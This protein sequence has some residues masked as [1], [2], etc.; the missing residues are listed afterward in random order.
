MAHWARVD[1]SRY[2]LY[3]TVRFQTFFFESFGMFFGVIGYVFYQTLKN[4]KWDRKDYVISLVAL[5][6]I[7]FIIII[8][9][10]FCKVISFRAKKIDRHI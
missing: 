2:V 9:F 8:D 6:V 4:Q 1:E 10:H 5:A 7:I 3:S